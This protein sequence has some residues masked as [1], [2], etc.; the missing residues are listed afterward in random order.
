MSKTCFMAE[1][2]ALNLIL[3]SKISKNKNIIGWGKIWPNIDSRLDLG[4]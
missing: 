1:E 3:M 2:N 4:I